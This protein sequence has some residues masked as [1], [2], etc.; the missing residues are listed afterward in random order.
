MI[1]VSY[2]IGDLFEAAFGYN[3]L[4]AFRIPEKVEGEGTLVGFEGVEV[5]REESPERMSWLGT[6]I[7]T[8]ITFQGGTYARYKEDGTI[9]RVQMNDFELPVASVVTIKRSKIL[10]KTKAT[11]NNG[12]VKEIYGFADWDVDIQGICLPDQSQPQGFF[13]AQSLLDELYR[14]EQLISP[15]R[16]LGGLSIN[17]NIHDIVIEDIDVR[18]L[19]GR[20]T[21]IPFVLKCV[22]DEPTELIL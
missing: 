11:A 13:T 4:P 2:N 18:Q 17:R 15:I 8:S 19:K 20:P 12:T 5:I 10:Q 1:G 14:W 21:V 16:I 22:S 3:R 9:E 7:L 6:P